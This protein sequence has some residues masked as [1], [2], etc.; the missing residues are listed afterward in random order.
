M[1]D[2]IEQFL[3]GLRRPDA[4]PLSNL[5]SVR[6]CGVHGYIMPECDRHFVVVIWNWQCKLLYLKRKKSVLLIDAG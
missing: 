1:F 4:Q 3:L 6:G 5:Q 2:N